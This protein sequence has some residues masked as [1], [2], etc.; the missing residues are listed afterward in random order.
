MLCTVPKI[1]LNYGNLRDVLPKDTP[2]L[3]CLRVICLANHASVETMCL[4]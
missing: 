3:A 2:A 4:R 1:F